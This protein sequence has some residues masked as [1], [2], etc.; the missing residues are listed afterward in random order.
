M[1]AVDKNYDEA[2]SAMLSLL[3]VNGPGLPRTH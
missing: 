1:Y 2:F 3:V